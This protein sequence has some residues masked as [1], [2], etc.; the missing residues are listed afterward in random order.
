MCPWPL[1]PLAWQAAVRV[2]GACHG[3]LAC[4]S[5][6]VCRVL[7]SAPGGERGT[8]RSSLFP[9]GVLR[10]ASAQR[11]RSVTALRVLLRGYCRV[12]GQCRRRPSLL[13][14]GVPK[15][16]CR[17]SDS[18][19]GLAELPGSFVLTVTVYDGGEI[20]ALTF[21]QSKLRRATVCIV[22]FPVLDRVRS[23]PLLRTEALFQPACFNDLFINTTGMSLFS[24]SLRFI[25]Q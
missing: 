5:W 13:S 14:S 3:D 15:S 12:R 16:T 4:V 20:I 19:G 21:E 17:F 25:D 22:S 18:R 23:A 11:A 9:L 6:P 24:R 2:S 8:F 7:P 10:T 1:V